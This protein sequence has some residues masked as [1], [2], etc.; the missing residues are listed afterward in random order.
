MVG[1][2]KFSSLYLNVKKKP[3]WDRVVQRPCVTA[4]IVTF[5]DR[6]EFSLG[7][8]VIRRHIPMVKIILNKKGRSA[9]NI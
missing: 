4:L 1:G 9:K 2:K 3:E 8:C 5:P 6:D 7:L